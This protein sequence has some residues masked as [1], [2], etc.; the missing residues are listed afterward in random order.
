MPLNLR[1]KTSSAIGPDDELIGILPVNKFSERSRILRRGSAN[2]RAGRF[3]LSPFILIFNSRKFLR[4]S[5]AAKLGNL[6]QN[7][8]SQHKMELG[9]KPCT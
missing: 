5:K 4:F 7:Y 2:S 1:S 8:T 9:C 3:P 6:H